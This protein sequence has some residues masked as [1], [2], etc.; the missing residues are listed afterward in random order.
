MKKLI[1]AIPLVVMFS[2]TCFAEWTKVFK[3]KGFMYGDGNTF[4]IDFSRVKNTAGTYII[5]AC[6]IF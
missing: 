3:G 4:Y 1:F 5:G 2:S 6:R